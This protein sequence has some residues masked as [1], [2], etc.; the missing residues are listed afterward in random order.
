MEKTDLGGRRY[1]QTIS[2]ISGFPIRVETQVSSKGNG[3]VTIENLQLR[4]YDAHGDGAHFEPSLLKTEFLDLNG[5]GYTDI[6]ISGTVVYD[7]H[8]KA[9]LEPEKN[10]QIWEPVRFV[11]H[12]D[13]A[14]DGFFL[15]T[16]SASFGLDPSEGPITS[17]NFLNNLSPDKAIP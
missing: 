8:E 7:Q 13:P 10:W 17:K 3:V 14:R 11:Y 16:Q 6:R 4:L 1:V 5:D 2:L 9:D 12:Y 15:Q